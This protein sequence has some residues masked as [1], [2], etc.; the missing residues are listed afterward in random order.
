MLATA[1]S[2]IGYRA[3]P[4]ASSEAPM[5]AGTQ[6]G[7]AV[8]IAAGAAPAL[9]SPVAVSRFAAAAVG[10]DPVA[11]AAAITALGEA[12][13]LE[14]LSI[15]QTVLRA[16]ETAVDRPLALRALRKI[17]LE[18]GDPDGGIR[19]VLRAGIY[20]GTG[21]ESAVRQDQAALDDIEGILSQAEAIAAS[22][23]PLATP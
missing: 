21:D 5:P 23:A 16:G 11:R 12:P 4:A 20:D 1:S 18:Q 8:A 10:D 2:T 6:S 9:L 19:D 3:A 7:A 15:L 13:R 17:A 22:R 14:A